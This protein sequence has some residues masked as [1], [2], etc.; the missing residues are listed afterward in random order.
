MTRA[1]PI[2]F[3]ITGD[4]PRGFTNVTEIESSTTLGQEQE[5]IKLLEEDC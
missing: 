2:A 1:S 5:A 4:R 3:K